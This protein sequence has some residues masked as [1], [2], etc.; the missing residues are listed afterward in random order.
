MLSQ[1]M[2]ELQEH[3]EDS[4]VQEQSIA[5]PTVGMNC[6]AFFPGLSHV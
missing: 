3:Y 2:D 6:A 4:G 5:N 1:L